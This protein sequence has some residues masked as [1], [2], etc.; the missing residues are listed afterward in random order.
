MRI[1]LFTFLLLTASNAI[2]QDMPD[3]DISRTKI[4][5]GIYFLEGRGGNMAVSIGED[6][7]FLI[8]DQFAPLT[9]KIEAN[10]SEM[11]ENPVRFIVNTHFHGDH[12]GGNETWAKKGTMLVAHDNVRKR[13][14]TEQ[15]NEG[16]GHTTPP[17]PEEAWPVITFSD[18]A[19]FHFN[20]EEIRLHHV[21]DAHTDGDAIVHFVGANVIHM[22]DIFFDGLYPFID[23]SGGGSIHG[24]IAAVEHVMTMIDDETVLVPGHGDVSDKAGLITYHKMLIGIREAIQAHIDDG[25]SVEDTVAAKPSAPWDAAWGEGFL[26]PDQFV[27]I[28]Y[29]GMTK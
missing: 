25:K 27:S 24:V 6:G 12:T 20:G 29:R 7:A 10:I 16:L 13:L 4:A 15:V 5:E 9:G 22:G 17:Q 11:T 2:A 14:M 21:S 1:A 18:N 23:F 26:N 19:T 3:V 28:T 8:D